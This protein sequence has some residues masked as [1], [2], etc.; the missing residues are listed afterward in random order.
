VRFIEFCAIFSGVFIAE[1][2]RK[3]FFTGGEKGM[4]KKPFS[5]N[6]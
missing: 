2:G 5:I 6:G 1:N 4:E 3:E